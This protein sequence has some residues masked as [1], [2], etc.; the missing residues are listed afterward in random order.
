MQTLN[1]I[2]KKK[3]NTNLDKIKAPFFNK[4][5]YKIYKSRNYQKIAILIR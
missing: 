5:N 3:K 4:Q 2:V 1:S